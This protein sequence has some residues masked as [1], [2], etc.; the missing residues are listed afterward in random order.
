[1]CAT[2]VL[3]PSGSGRPRRPVARGAAWVIPL[4]ALTGLATGGADGPEI[5]EIVGAEV[6]S[7]AGVPC[8]CC[9]ETRSQ[10][11][12]PRLLGLLGLPVGGR[13]ATHGEW[14]GTLV[15]AEELAAG[16][17]RAQACAAACSAA[18]PT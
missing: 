4:A 18:T 13:P 2:L 7:V 9:T 15:T 3:A 11:R 12:L 6:A 5:A 8:T 1:M 17:I 14:P 10:P 16:V